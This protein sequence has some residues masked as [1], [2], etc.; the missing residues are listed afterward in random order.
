MRRDSESSGIHYQEVKGQKRNTMKAIM[1]VE[2]QSVGEC[3]AAHGLSLYI[4]TPDHRLLFDL[5]P[6]RTF[7][8][9]AGKLGVG[10]EKVDTVIISHGHYDHGGG[11]EEFLK[12]NSKARVYI[13]KNAF[14]PHYSTAQGKARNIGLKPELASHPQVVLLEGDFQIDR[15][16]ELFT[17]TGQENCHSQ[18]NDV[19]LDEKGRDAFAHEQNL[20]IHG[21][22]PVLIMGCGHKGVVNIMEKASKWNPKVCIGGFH[23]NI[24]ATGKAVP[25]NV[26]EE[27][28]VQLKKYDTRFYTCHCTGQEAYD[29]LAQRMKI[30]YLRCGEGLEI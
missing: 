17:V 7:L 15:E 18:A 4:E 6:D 3:K 10:L 14:E 5:G 2:N 9:N 22:D 28:A 8:E 12:L 1:L 21:E 27:I 24:P 13:Q 20:L 30:Q 16:L 23:L 25:Q 26:L 11:L 29:Y 19:L